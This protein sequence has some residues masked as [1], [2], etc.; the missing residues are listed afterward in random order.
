M[1]F[2]K[3]SEDELILAHLIQLRKW[4]SEGQFRKFISQLWLKVLGR[5]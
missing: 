5:I 1:R 2:E 4:E 3:K